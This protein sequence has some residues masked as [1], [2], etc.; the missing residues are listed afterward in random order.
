MRIDL[1]NGCLCARLFVPCTS[2]IFHRIS[3]VLRAVRRRGSQMPLRC[4]SRQQRPGFIAATILSG[5][6][7]SWTRHKCQTSANVQRAKPC[8]ERS[9]RPAQTM[10]HD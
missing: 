1:H 7:K 9:Q 3:Q 6:S 10:K 8:R 5:L 2:F 4:S